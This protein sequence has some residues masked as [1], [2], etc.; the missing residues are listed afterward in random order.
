MSEYDP[1]INPTGDDDSSQDR[2]ID[3][4]LRPLTLDEFIGQPKL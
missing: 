1:L 2:V 4:A 3:R